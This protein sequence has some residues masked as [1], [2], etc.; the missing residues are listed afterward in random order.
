MIHLLLSLPFTLSLSHIHDRE[1]RCPCIHLIV[2]SYLF[3]TTGAFHFRS[4]WVAREV[5]PTELS[6]SNNDCVQ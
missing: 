2:M 5:P 3:S 4:Q 6:N 1:I